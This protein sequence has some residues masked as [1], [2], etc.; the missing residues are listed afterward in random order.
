MKLLFPV[1]V[2][3]AAI[4]PTIGLD[5]SNRYVRTPVTKDR[6][7]RRREVGPQDYASHE[8]EVPKYEQKMPETVY[9]KPKEHDHHKPKEHDH[10]KPK[11]HDHHKPA[12]EPT[13]EPTHEVRSM[14]RS[15]QCT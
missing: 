14:E 9:H 10:H 8:E 12:K 4:D 11:E 1:L 13:K 7:L 5:E 15:R 6:D 2:A 3:L